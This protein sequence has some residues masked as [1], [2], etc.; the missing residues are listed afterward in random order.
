MIYF[1]DAESTVVFVPQKADLLKVDCF[2]FDGTENYLPGIKETSIDFSIMTEK[3]D[4]V[5]ELGL[6]QD[7]VKLIEYFRILR[8]LIHF[9]E[10]GIKLNGPL[11]LQG[12]SVPDL[13]IEFVNA[14]VVPAA[15]R[16]IG[17]LGMNTPN[18]AGLT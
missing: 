10:G 15:N 14:E 7:T 3:P 5:R 2:R 11:N 12:K 13:V 18:L 4:Y 8:N 17:S 6:P 16:V 1:E 9:P